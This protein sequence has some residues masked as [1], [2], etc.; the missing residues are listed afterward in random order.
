MKRAELLDVVREGRSAVLR[1]MGNWNR[2]DLTPQARALLKWAEGDAADALKAAPAP[3]HD[4]P[5]GSCPDLEACP[6]CRMDRLRDAARHALDEMDVG[7]E[8]SR[9]FRSSIVK[10][11][12]ALRGVRRVRR[13]GKDIAPTA[14]CSG[15]G[16]KLTERETRNHRC[17]EARP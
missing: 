10:L 16:M 4:D 1:L 17:P 8:Q 6:A 9:A 3:R 7:G 12:R 14:P 11:R 5:D 2:A 15:C 13:A